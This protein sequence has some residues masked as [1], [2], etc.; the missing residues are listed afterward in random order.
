VEINHILRQLVVAAWVVAAILAGGLAAF[1]G[2]R[3]IAHSLARGDVTSYADDLLVRAVTI[4]SEMD[5]SL[6]EANQSTAIPCS[7][8][9]I[10]KLR[11]IAFTR[12]FVK[13]V[14]RLIAGKLA[15]S[16]FLGTLPVPIVEKAPDLITGTGRKLWVSVALQLGVGINAMVVEAGTSNVVVDLAAF[17]DLERPPFR[18]S[19]AIIDLSHR[20]VLRSWGKR[21]VSDETL[22]AG[23]ASFENANELVSARCSAA[24]SICGVAAL[25]RSEAISRQLP[26]IYGFI[27]F[28]GVAGGFLAIM[29]TFML[30]RQKPLLTRLVEALKSEE[31]AV[32][33][34]PIVE[35]NTGRMVSAEALVRWTDRK[36][37]VIAPDIF[38][39]AAEEAGVAGQITTCALR[40]VTSEAGRFLRDNPDVRITV[41]MVAAD[42]GDTQFYA[43]LD[44]CV[45]TAG[46]SASQIGLELTERSTAALD[47]AV[48]AIA[49]LRNLGHR[50]YLD[51]FGTGYSSLSNLQDL[52]VDTIK[53]DR[54]FTSTVG[55]ASV[56]VSLVP[57]ILDMANALN[58]GVVVEGIET[59]EQL[60]YFAAVRPPCSGQGWF[61]S[62]PL[63]LADLMIFHKKHRMA[64]M[65]D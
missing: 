60:D 19:I 33:Y 51:D 65:I 14:G 41:N 7:V 58:L 18:Y 31:L 34:Q 46:I 55:T 8:E 4:A 29:A 49:R 28:G 2:A 6:D 42:L 38:V 35:L 56:K 17:L 15:C 27:G 20:R 57:Q 30:R 63:E 45:R 40:K 54:V 61:I 43:E 50:V 47:I 39:S 16:S 26:F 53:I 37:N 13:D 59:K 12:R 9:D 25:D 10:S 5:K 32:V 44:R 64:S 22:I 48:A 36:G 24:Y 1:A 3:F 23:D 21:L 62:P 52:N 11:Q